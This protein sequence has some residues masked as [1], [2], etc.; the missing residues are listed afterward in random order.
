LPEEEL[1]VKHEAIIFSVFAQIEAAIEKRSDM[2]M[3]LYRM[4]K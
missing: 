4:M 2:L 1:S 3:L